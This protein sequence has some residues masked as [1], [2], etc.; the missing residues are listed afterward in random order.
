MGGE[1]GGDVLPQL[2]EVGD[3]E[4]HPAHD[5]GKDGVHMA[6]PFGGLVQPP[7]QED[8]L[9][10]QQHRVIEAPQHEVPAGP[11]PQAR[12]EPDDSQIQ[13]LPSLTVAV[14]AQ[15]DIDIFPEPGAQADVPA[16][17]EFRDGAGLVGV[18][19][20]FQEMEAKQMPQADGHVGVS[21]EI[22]V[23]LEGE[24]D[25]A[26]PR[27]HGGGCG[28][29]ADLLPQSAHLIGDQH[30]FGQAHH[31]ALH[32]AA[33]LEHALP[34]V[35]QL[36]LH[37]LVLDDGAGDQLGEQRHIRAH[38]ED[39]FLVLDNAPVHV[40]G[41]GHGLEGVEADADGQGQSQC[42]DA[43]A[44]QAVQVIDGEIRVL[45]E[46]QD[47]QVAHHIHD[48]HRLGGLLL[49]GIPEMADEPG[50]GV[51]E[52]R[53]EQHD[54]DILRLTPAVEHQAEQQQHGIACLAGTQEIDSRHHGQ[55]D[56]QKGGAA[57]YHKAFSFGK[58][59]GRLRRF[60]RKV[61]QSSALSHRG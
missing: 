25:S 4:Q 33:G 45:E 46:A 24:G 48:Q 42:G 55:E 18:F 50:V 49:S 35:H 1:H 59:T 61:G 5:E 3:G 39:V 28:H 17:P 51:V 15:R 56:Q 30:L 8:L 34:A 38:V 10:D 27:R 21:G 52:H 36:V 58:F 16:P 14:A 7:Q 32:T 12:Q 11:V 60:C 31:K 47:A 53:G 43:R 19:K 37:R 41:V 20:V 57:E 2:A 29:G 9:Q 22:E 23:D 40:D 13:N 44:Q 6:H 54:Q 26:Q